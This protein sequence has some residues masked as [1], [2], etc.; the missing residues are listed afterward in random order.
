MGEWERINPSPGRHPNSWPSMIPS[1]P[2]QGKVRSEPKTLT[3]H[4][5]VVIVTEIVYYSNIQRDIRSTQPRKKSFLSTKFPVD[6]PDLYARE[7]PSTRKAHN[8]FSTASLNTSTVR[9]CHD[10]F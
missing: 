10:S 4:H 5:R 7:H 3:S 8:P 1:T 6:L 2:G 9:V